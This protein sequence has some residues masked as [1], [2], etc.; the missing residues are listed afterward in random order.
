MSVVSPAIGKFP[1]TSALTESILPLP[2][3][4][5]TTLIVP[6]N[7][8]SSPQA[9]SGARGHPPDSEDRPPFAARRRAHTHMTKSRRVSVQRDSTT[10]CLDLSGMFDAR[11]RIRGNGVRYSF[12][13]NKRSR[14]FGSDPWLSKA[15]AHF[16][17]ENTLRNPWRPEKS[18]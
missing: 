9:P 2:C 12:L 4:F 8:N 7:Y 3:P 18:T 6:V 13:S 16:G 10:L 5:T 15:V 17:L 1:L 14:P 11:G